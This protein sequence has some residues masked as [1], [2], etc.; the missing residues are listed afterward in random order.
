VKGRHLACVLTYETDKM[1][2]SYM[3][4]MAVTEARENLAEVIERARI[5]HEP[6]HLT[7]RGRPI[8]VIIDAEDFKRMVA[9]AEDALDIAAADAAE[10]AGDFVPWEQV[11]A[12]LGLV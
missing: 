3:T 4:V 8:A 6:V 12:E 1:Y 11:K 5:D 10:E 9:I 7:R 2:G